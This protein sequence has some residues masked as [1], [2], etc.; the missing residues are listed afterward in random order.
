MRQRWIKPLFL[1]VLLLIFS[2]RVS[3]TSSQEQ[4]S[5]LWKVQ[6]RG[7]TVYLLGSIH[8][9][10]KEIYP[11]HRRIEEA[12]DRSA[13]LVVE[14]DVNRLD[15]KVLQKLMETAFYPENET[16]ESHVSPETFSLIKKEFA[17]MS[18]PLELIQ[19]QKPWFLA[20]TISALSYVKIGLD[21]AYGIDMYFL[22]KAQGKKRILELE[23]LEEQLQFLSQ[24]SDR[25]QESLLLYEL[26]SKNVLE[27]ETNQLVQTWL[28]GDVRG[29][30]SILNRGIRQD[31]WLSSVYEKMVDER[32]RK[33]ALKIEEFLG[34]GKDYFVIVGA[35]H[36]VGD[37]GIPEV[38]R[39]KGYSVEQL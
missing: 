27:K 12:F 8:L 6:S 31:P 38:L 15:P 9:L 17:E 22:S 3:R 19:K 18:F 35:G 13:V 11:L 29:M 14:A 25:E 10:K 33:M 21:P 7:N 26:K 1:L 24:L 32:N 34:A 28:S 5:F 36:L 30:E 16:L 20:L 39:R 37:Q 2:L 23:S 4:K